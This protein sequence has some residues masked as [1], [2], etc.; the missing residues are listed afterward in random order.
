MIKVEMIYGGHHWEKQNLVTKRDRK[1]MFDEYMCSCCGIKGKSYTFG[2]IEVSERYKTEKLQKCKWVMKSTQIKV[3]H[4]QAEGPQFAN[5][6]DGSVHT[7]I[8]P[9]KGCDNKRG[10]WVM[11]VGEP[12]LVLANEFTYIK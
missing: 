12:V 3:I 1:G 4:C 10:E 9:P 2:F 6:K 8:D 7:I 11:G 5:L